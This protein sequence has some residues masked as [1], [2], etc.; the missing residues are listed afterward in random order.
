MQLDNR[1]QLYVKEIHTTGVVINTAVVMAAA[2]GI[3]KHHDANLVE[4]DGPI[5]IAKD[6]AR[7]LLMRMHFVKRR[8]NT[9]AKVSF[10]DFVQF[11]VQLLMML[12][13]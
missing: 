10:P 7:S 4:D 11:K 6:W 8:A 9:K 13:Q 5:T 1:V 3:V 2:E 12:E